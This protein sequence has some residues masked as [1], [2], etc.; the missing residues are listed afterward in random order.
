MFKSNSLYVVLIS[1]YAFVVNWISGNVGV[2]P[3]DTFSFFDTSYSILEGKY[4]IRDFW[5]FS[6][7]LLDYL[8]ALF[9]VLIGKNWTA[10]VI[11]ACFFNILKY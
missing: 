8:Q 11:H 3:I 10:Y 7:I 6:G 2:M 9:F 5:I 1:F 4:P